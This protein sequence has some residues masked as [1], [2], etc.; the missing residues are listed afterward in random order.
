VA[1]ELAVEEKV[2][3]GVAEGVLV[4]ELVAVKV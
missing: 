3:V 2:A 1:V 4:K